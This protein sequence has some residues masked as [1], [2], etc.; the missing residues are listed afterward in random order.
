MHIQQLLKWHLCLK[1]KK[2]STTWLLITCTATQLEFTSCSPKGSKPAEKRM[3][4]RI[5]QCSNAIQQ[6]S[7]WIKVIEDAWAIC[8][9]EKP[10]KKNS[11]SKGCIKLNINCSS[12]TRYSVET[13]EHVLAVE[14]FCVTNNIHFSVIHSP[15]DAQ[16][17]FLKPAD[18]I[19]LSWQ[20]HSFLQTIS[21]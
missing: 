19:I 21:F 1:K 4:N 13:Q 16:L 11:K 5:L 3:S 7:K 18:K 8:H 12:S 20:K 2:K 6:Q 10:W 17:C 9:G 14:V 15:P